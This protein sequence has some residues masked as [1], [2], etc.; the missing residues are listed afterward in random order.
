MGQDSDKTPNGS[1]LVWKPGSLLIHNLFFK[2]SCFLS[3]LLALSSLLAEA[4]KA[5]QSL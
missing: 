2:Y 1:H 5:R 4:S 3:G